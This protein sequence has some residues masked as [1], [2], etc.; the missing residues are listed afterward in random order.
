METCPKCGGDDYVG[1]RSYSGRGM[2]TIRYYHCSHC[3]Y[4]WERDPAPTVPQEDPLATVVRNLLQELVPGTIVWR[5]ACGKTYRANDM[6]DELD[7]GSSEGKQ[8]AADLLRVSR[9][10]L[11][12]QAARGV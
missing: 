9:D 6:L 1:A 8:Y 3:D 2:P 5:T 11:A 7:K 12:R 4:G 10:F